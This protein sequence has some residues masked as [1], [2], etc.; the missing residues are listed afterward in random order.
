MIKKKGASNY[1]SKA[2]VEEL[3]LLSQTTLPYYHTTTMKDSDSL[4]EDLK[5]AV[6]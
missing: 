6:E 4:L 2:I 1:K 3:M 5:T